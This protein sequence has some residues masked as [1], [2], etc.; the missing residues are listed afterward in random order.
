MKSP[1]RGMVGLR[2]FDIILG[3]FSH[4]L[5]VLHAMFRMRVG[6]YIGILTTRVSFFKLGRVLA[7]CPQLAQ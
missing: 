1:I 2:S 5:L 7:L 3:N 4:T 6:H